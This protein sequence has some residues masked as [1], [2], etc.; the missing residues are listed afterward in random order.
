MKRTLHAILTFIILAGLSPDLAIGQ[1]IKTVDGIKVISNGRKPKPPPGTPVQLILEE[2]G[3]I[4]AGGDPGKSFAELTLFVVDRE[5]TIFGLDMKDRNIKAF[6][7]DGG[8]LMTI[9]KP[10]Q[11]PGELSMPS[12]IQLNSRGELVIEDVLNRRLAFFT[13]QGEYIKNISLADKLGLVNI[14]IDDNDGMLGREM[15]VEDK[16]M[17]FK[18]TK[19][20]SELKALFTIDK[21]AFEVPIPGSGV[22]I[23]IMDMMALYDQA[24]DGRI[25]YSRNQ[26]YAVQVY[27]GDGRHMSTIRKPF[28]SVDV[29]EEDIEE[30]LAR[31]PNMGGPVN[32]RDVLEFPEKF[33][34]MQNMT[35][36]EMGRLHVRTWEKGE[37]EGEYF[38][39]VFDGEGRYIARYVGKADIR[40]W[41]GGAAYAIEEDE[42]GFKMI[43]RYRVNWK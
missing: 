19:F 36:D 8:F 18:I 17:F 11:G 29:T 2:D 27:S 23:N 40:E 24:P 7:R 13:R 28:K 14:M 6:D 15:G 34:P 39:D 33:P 25:F 1:K 37:V 3:R 32:V 30:M 4:G 21:I 38:T 5:G 41:K 42:D 16:K 35:L 22:K 43:K 31:I 12:G 20:D 10:G 26:E 9:G